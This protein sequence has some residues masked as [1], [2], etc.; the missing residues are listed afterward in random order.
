MSDEHEESPDGLVSIAPEPSRG[1]F[2]F[3]VLGTTIAAGL[4]ATGCA[5]WLPEPMSWGGA[6]A[7]SLIGGVTAAMLAGVPQRQGEAA[8]LRERAAREEERKSW[9]AA[10]VDLESLRRQI[11]LATLALRGRKDPLVELPELRVGALHDLLEASRDVGVAGPVVS[12]IAV[13]EAEL[14]GDSDRIPGFL[15]GEPLDLPATIGFDPRLRREA[16]AAVDGLIQS[17]EELGEEIEAAPEP[18]SAPVASGSPAQ[19]VD[20]VVQ[21]AA[22]GIE[23]L[24]A[25]LMRANELAVV[26]ERV[27]NRATLLALN[28][29]L[30]ATRTGGEAMGAIAEETRRLAEYAR[31]ATDTISRLAGEIEVKVG[32]TITAIHAT[33][34]DAKAGLATLSTG[35]APPPPD[36]SRTLGALVAVLDKAY[37]LRAKLADG[38]EAAPESAPQASR[39]PAVAP[40]PPSPV[41]PR[42]PSPS[43]EPRPVRTEAPPPQAQAEVAWAEPETAWADAVESLTPEQRQILERLQPELKRGPER[44]G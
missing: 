26:A 10:V 3:S 2:S 18:G 30:E 6:V 29:A 14:V 35:A 11:N 15:E 44:Q 12:R 40:A 19:L 36:T 9:G 25:G 7:I 34:E 37:D 4:V 43:A 33:S 16:L 8:L 20:S 22:D 28:A 39:A 27:T 5:L 38:D 23:D 21:T 13:D 32:E 31:E 17:L 42:A 1:L 41:P 24:A